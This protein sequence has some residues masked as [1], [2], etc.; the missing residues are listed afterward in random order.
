ML[1]VRNHYIHIVATLRRF[2]G[3]MSHLCLSVFLSLS[4]ERMTCTICINYLPAVPGLVFNQGAQVCDW[5]FN[6]D[7]PCGTKGGV[8]PKPE[9]KMKKPSRKMTKSKYERRR[10]KATRSRE[11]RVMQ[12][13]MRVVKEPKVR[14][15]YSEKKRSKGNMMLRETVHGM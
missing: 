7:A 9:K 15:Q 5:P 4:P 8:T 10:V 12:L 1:P 6:V 2:D 11:E 14:R 3:Y 13:K